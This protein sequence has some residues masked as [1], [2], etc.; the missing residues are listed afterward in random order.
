MTK[1]TLTAAILSLGAA[2]VLTAPAHAGTIA[3]TFPTYYDSPDGYDFV[4]TF[5]PPGSTTIGTFTFSIPAS[6][7]LGI[8]ISGTFGNPDNPTTALSDYYLGFSGDETA[9]EVA[10]CDSVVADCYSNEDGPTVWAYTLTAGNLS[11]LAPAIAGG[12]LDFTYT[13]DNNTVVTIPGDDQY[14]Y[15]GDP[16]LDI[17]VSPEP[18]TVLLCFGGL[19]ALLALRR[20]RKV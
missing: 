1:R 7:L 17:T 14:V 3:V 10:A 19:A 4:T 16:T 9:V 13:W 12:S 5:P 8:T 11:T 18:A 15:A 2:F 6:E 20:F